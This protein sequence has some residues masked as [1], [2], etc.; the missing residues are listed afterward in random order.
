MAVP[1]QQ[2]ADTLQVMVMIQRVAATFAHFTMA[3]L[4]P[5]CHQN[6]LVILGK[7]SRDLG[8]PVST[9][10]RTA[11]FRWMVQRPLEKSEVKHKR[12]LILEKRIKKKMS[13]A[14]LFNPILFASF[15][16]ERL[17]GSF[18]F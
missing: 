11:A 14:I 5:G 15:N 7:C 12:L 16:G 18:A 8:I 10:H 3:A 13:P 4:A 9:H 17:P 6:A 2:D 1:D